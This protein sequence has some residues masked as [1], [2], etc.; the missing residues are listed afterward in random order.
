MVDPVEETGW[1]EHQALPPFQGA[2]QR[3]MLPGPGR[4]P[5]GFQD[6]RDSQGVNGPENASWNGNI[7]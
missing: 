5:A 7:E 4:E 1:S 2:E 6:A 3:L